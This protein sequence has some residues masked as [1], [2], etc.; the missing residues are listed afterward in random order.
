MNISKTYNVVV[1][2]V[3]IHT[4]YAVHAICKHLIT[5]AKTKLPIAVRQSHELIIDMLGCVHVD[6]TGMILK[7][8]L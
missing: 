5:K 7:V 8:Q 1:T 3:Y 2:Y 6:A 4:T